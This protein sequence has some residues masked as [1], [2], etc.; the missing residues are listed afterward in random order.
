MNLPRYTA[1]VPLDAIPYAC[2]E[3][4]H[5]SWSAPERRVIQPG[6]V[7]VTI[8]GAPTL[9]TGWDD[10]GAWIGEYPSSDDSGRAVRALSLDDPDNAL[11]G[12]IETVAEDALPVTVRLWLFLSTDTTTPVLTERY[13]V[14][15]SAPAAERLELQCVSR[16]LSVLADPFIRHTRSNSPG[17]RGR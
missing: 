11:H 6:D 3:I 9:F 15:S 16:D 12:L 5:P 8:D 10:A 2:L 17:L 13:T 4:T 7:T 14:Q 1:S